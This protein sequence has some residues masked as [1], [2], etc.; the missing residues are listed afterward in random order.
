[1]P[2]V[3][4]ESEDE[5][6]DAALDEAKQSIGTFFENLV[7]PKANQESFLVKVA[8]ESEDSVEH[9]WMADLDV[10][11]RPIVGT[12]ANEPSI[13]GLKFMDRVPI[14]PAR[15]TDWMFVEDGYLIGGYSTKLIRSKMSSDE[16]A[17]YDRNAPYKFRD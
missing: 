8:F 14:D 1:M 7:S 3:S 16:R 6:M 4:F 12:V 10:T 9:I 5:E 15:I 11:V 2:L 17:E 13:P